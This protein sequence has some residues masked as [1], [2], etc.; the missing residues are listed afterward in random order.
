MRLINNN[1]TCRVG[2]GSMFI[3]EFLA[4]HKPVTR[5]EIMETQPLETE[6]LET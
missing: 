6:P 2:G 5:P 3:E 4:T 1:L